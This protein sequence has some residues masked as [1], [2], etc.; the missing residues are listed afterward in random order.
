[1]DKYYLP[2]PNDKAADWTK[3]RTPS[4]AM[5]LREPF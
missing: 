4:T 1:M 5:P 3:N 2:H